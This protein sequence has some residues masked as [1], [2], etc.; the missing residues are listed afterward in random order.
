MPRGND[1]APP[2]TARPL[3]HD[4]LDEQT[5]AKLTEFAEEL[6]TRAAALGTA[7]EAFSHE[8]AAAVQKAEQGGGDGCGGDRSDCL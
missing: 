2:R 5:I 4:M 7:P 6:D 3:A 1:P 8:D